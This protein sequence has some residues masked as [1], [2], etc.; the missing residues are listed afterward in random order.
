MDTKTT[1]R[2]AVLAVIALTVGLLRASA[3]LASDPPRLMG[4]KVWPSPPAGSDVSRLSALSSKGRC[5]PFAEAGLTQCT[6]SI[7]P[8]S[9]EIGQFR[10]NE[11]RTLRLEDASSNDYLVITDSNL[12]RGIY[13]DKLIDSCLAVALAAQ[14][15]GKALSLTL[16]VK[17]DVF[18]EGALKDFTRDFEENGGFLLNI[19]QPWEAVACVLK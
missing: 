4:V 9:V 7:V 14:T 5:T 10:A 11:E 18:P 13:S 2:L 15:S 1:L 17:N 19:T 16:L 6:R 12:A 8:T 3:L